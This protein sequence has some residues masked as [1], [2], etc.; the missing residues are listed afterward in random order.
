MPQGCYPGTTG[1]R[2]A[3]PALAENS[4]TLPE[5]HQAFYIPVRNTQDSITSAVTTEQS[6]AKVSSMKT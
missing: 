5:I 1:T 2:G 4:G 3:P 6:G